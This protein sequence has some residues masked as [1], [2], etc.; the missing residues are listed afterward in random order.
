VSF[1]RLSFFFFTAFFLV[2]IAAMMFIYALCATR[3][4]IVYMILFADLLVVFALLA[5]PYWRLG[6]EDAE[7]GE[8]LTVVSLIFRCVSATKPFDI[9]LTHFQGG[10]TARFLA[11]MLDFY[12]LTAQ[13]LDA[14]GY[15]VCIACWGPERCTE[16]SK[17]QY[18]IYAKLFSHHQWPQ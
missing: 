6:Q 7:V 18:V 14:V 3:T 5:A 11:S 8:R 4:N 12:L 1:F 16:P 2:F 15:P 9:I 17:N 13:L 10:G